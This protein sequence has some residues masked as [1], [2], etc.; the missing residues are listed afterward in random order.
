MYHP[1][2]DAT[3]EPLGA[4]PPEPG[5]R[6]PAPSPDLH[7]VQDFVNTND[8]EGE[9]DRLATPALLGEWLTARGA[10]RSGV[11]VPPEAHARAIAVREG[12]RALAR[13]NNEEALE[14]A[15]VDALNRVT[16]HLPLVAD[17][18]DGSSW[19][20][21]GSATGVD[22]YLARI[23]ANVVTAMAD[24]SWS[25]VKACRNDECRWLFYDS[26]RNRSGTWCTM[27]ICGS[28]MKARS[29]RAR[30]K[31]AS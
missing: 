5:G 28:R 25:R 15:R 16:R 9:N 30:K 1:G 2:M 29:Y 19:H 3:L 6:P 7:E 8:I 13:A 20:L 12:L 27:A 18:G 17:L 4:D 26:S 10:L 31:T 11:R 23:V 22:G 24:G 21:E 14:P